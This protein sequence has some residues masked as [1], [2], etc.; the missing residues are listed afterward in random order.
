MKAMGRDVS[1]CVRFRTALSIILTASPSVMRLSHST[2]RSV[3]VVKAKEM[4]PMITLIKES[5]ESAVLER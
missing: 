4:K 2:R 1:R 5:G 3:R